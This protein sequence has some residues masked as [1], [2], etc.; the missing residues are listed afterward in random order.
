MYVDSLNLDFDELS[1]LFELRQPLPG[2]ILLLNSDKLT[3][4]LSRVFQG[5]GRF[6]HVGIVVAHD[7]YVDAIRKV[8]VKFRPVQDL[9]SPKQA[10]VL[11]RCEVARSRR[12]L[13]K[14]SKLLAHSVAFSGRKYRLSSLFLRSGVN[15]AIQRPLIC[16]SLV[17]HVVHEVSRLLRKPPHRALPSHIDRISRSKGWSR[18]PLSEYDFVEKPA[19]LRGDRLKSQELWLRSVPAM[20]SIDAV[21]RRDAR[22]GP[23]NSLP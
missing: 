19:V 22:Q 11:E 5:N 12:L 2:D 3:G 16:S 15:S 6:S 17:T 18:F 14:G 7:I 8:G 23:P 1:E 10:Y 13:R 20:H 4:R 21:W 9:L